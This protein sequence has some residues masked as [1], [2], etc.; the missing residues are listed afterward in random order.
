MELKHKTGN[1]GYTWCVWS[2][3]G[4]LEAGFKLLQTRSL[5]SNLPDAVCAMRAVLANQYRAGYRDTYF[6][7]VIYHITHRSYTYLWFELPWI[8]MRIQSSVQICFCGSTAAKCGHR[9][10]F[11]RS[12]WANTEEQHYGDPEHMKFHNACPKIEEV[13]SP[14]KHWC[15]HVGCEEQTSNSWHGAVALV[16]ESTWPQTVIGGLHAA[17]SESVHMFRVPSSI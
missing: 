17:N 15:W 4:W 10:T 6:H 16:C 2:P 3:R 7:V 14:G 9:A 1:A 12:M 5:C 13:A 8:R 11:T